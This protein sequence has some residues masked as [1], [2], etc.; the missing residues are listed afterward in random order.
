LGKITV[1]ITEENEQ[2]LREQNR[3]KGD[4]SNIINQALNQYFKEGKKQ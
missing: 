3:K 2:K 4:I 1:I